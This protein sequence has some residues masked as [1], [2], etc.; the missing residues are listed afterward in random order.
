M[1]IWKK[2]SMELGATVTISPKQITKANIEG[3]YGPQDEW[4]I[5]LNGEN[6]TSYTGYKNGQPDYYGKIFRGNIGGSFTMRKE[7]DPTKNRAKYIIEGAK[8]GQSTPP[9]QTAPQLPL[10]KFQQAVERPQTAPVVRKDVKSITI[11]M[12]ACVKAAGNLE[13]KNVDELISDATYIFRSVALFAE[14]Y[15][16]DLD[17]IENKMVAN[18]V[19]VEFWDWLI[20]VN[21]VLDK[22]DLTAEATAYTL[23]AFPVVVKRYVDSTKPKPEEIPQQEEDVIREQ[24]FAEA[25]V[26]GPDNTSYPADEQCPEPVQAQ[27]LPF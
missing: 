8:A 7:F 6:A 25:L 4:W 22:N 21:G 26:E 18:K 1:T 2:S 9:A 24:T 27:I 11:G 10:T 12:Y 17:K 3:N 15:R 13:H 23:K 20:G 16:P 19:P 14:T 5:E